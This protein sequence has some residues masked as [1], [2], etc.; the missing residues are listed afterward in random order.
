[1]TE[2]KPLPPIAQSAFT[3]AQANFQRQMMDLCAETLA[4]M[5]LSPVDGWKVN[6][7][8]GTVVR[9]VAEPAKPALVRDDLPPAI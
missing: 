2:T 6:V 5:G 8:Q 9:E 4:T 7:E 3:Y 1:M